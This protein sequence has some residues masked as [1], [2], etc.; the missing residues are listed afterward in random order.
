M[1]RIILLAASLSALCLF[2]VACA[3][4][5]C[6]GLSQTRSVSEGKSLLACAS[7]S[8][9]GF[10]QTRS[11]SE[12]K[13]QPV[14]EVDWPHWRGP[15]FDGVSRETGL[16][17]EWPEG[18]PR[19]LWK[20][21]LSGGYSSVAVAGGRLYTHTAKNKKEEIV[22]C[23][24]AA[25]GKELWRYTYPCDYDRHVTLGDRY[26]SGPRAT[27]ALESGRIYT[28]GTT[29]TVL[30]LEAATGKIVWRREL[31]DIAGRS[32]PRQGYCA[33]PLVIGDLLFV[34]P[35]GHK[36]NSVAALNKTDGKLVW[37][38]LDD[39]ISHA[40]PIRVDVQRTPQVVFL[41]ANSLAGFAP[42]D[43]K[44]LWRYD[45]GRADGGPDGIMLP[46]ATPVY[47]DGRFFL[48]SNLMAGMLLR[49]KDEGAPEKVWTSS[50][51]NPFATSVLYGDHLYGFGGS[52]LRCVAWASGKTVWDESGL[53]K[54]AVA[55]ADGRLIV[56]TEAGELFLA[57]A[58]PKGYGQKGRCQPM[59]GPC[60]TAPVVA[61]GRL[62]LRNE[63]LLMA[64]ELKGDRR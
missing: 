17:K 37:Q 9:D 34:H 6:G 8:C 15:H 41:T 32:C 63:R 40:S 11:V 4:G 38:A 55:L 42:K 35:G 3:S 45:L 52:R 31:L 2:L 7:G 53:G 20:V 10:S 24:E 21:E 49:L 59:E 48:S 60:L 58:T 36:G 1:Q 43:G 47:A 13:K 64:L 16:L 5:L 14:R 62:F 28:I 39:A 27:P 23:L 18:G 12:D 51:R 56:L 22:L 57:E 54:G 46:A 30:C 50:M 33:S 25:T 61:V 19:V 44:L 29:G 26:D